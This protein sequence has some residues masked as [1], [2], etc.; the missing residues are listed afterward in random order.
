MKSYKK[1]FPSVFVSLYNTKAIKLSKTVVIKW[2]LMIERNLFPKLINHFF[3]VVSDR[4]L[5]RD[6][7]I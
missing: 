3:E 4:G 1:S 7:L 6:V 2:F 5:A